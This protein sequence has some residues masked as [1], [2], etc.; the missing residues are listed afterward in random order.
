MH[1]KY[2]SIIYI[3]YYFSAFLS[4]FFCLSAALDSLDYLTEEKKKKNKR[5]DCMHA[6]VIDLLLW[7]WAIREWETISPWKPK[8]SCWAAF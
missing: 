2:H 4:V 5:W 7:I 6:K 8:P 3:F 1:V